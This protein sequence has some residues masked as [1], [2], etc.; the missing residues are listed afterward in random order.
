MGRKSNAK[1]QLKEAILK[2]M[3]EQSYGSLTI[4]AICAAAQVKKGSFYYFYPGKAELAADALQNCFDCSKAAM[5]ADFSATKTAWER[6]ESLGNRIY[7]MQREIFDKHGKVLGCPYFNVGTE[8]CKLEPVVAQQIDKVL[9]E[10]LKYFVSTARDAVDTSG[11]DPDTLG[12]C[13]FHLFEGTLTRARI[14][15]DP[16]LIKDFL[17]GAKKLLGTPEEAPVS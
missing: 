3:W 14:N 6:I 9:E 2:L 7:T 16:E 15:N 10:Y 12:R 11:L 13:L 8:I 17:V 1:E 4:D 5:D